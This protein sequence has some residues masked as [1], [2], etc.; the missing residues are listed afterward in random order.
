MKDNK[1]TITGKV[2][3]YASV[4]SKVTG[5]VARMAGNKIIG[6]NDI[7][8]NADNILNAL[9]GLKGPLM[10]VAQ[11]LATIPDALPKEYAE[12]LQTLQSEAPSMGWFFVKRRMAGELGNEWLNKFEAFDKKAIKAASLGQVH[13]A[14]AN[15]IIIACK[16]QYPDMISIVDADLKQ[17]KLIFTIYGTW[18][19]T[20][21]TKDIYEELT[22][23]LKEE[24]DYNKEQKNMLLFNEILKNEKY[25]KV[26]K[27]IKKLSTDKLLTMTWL[28]GD[29]IM[30]WKKAKSEIK[31]HLAL[32]LFNAWYI[33]F[34]KY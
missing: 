28:E 5:V 18:D 26:P 13:K 10:K 30:N 19:K 15:G 21:K 14:K 24:L 2:K 6:N 31:N 12:K 27:P 7:N 20:I 32:T 3:R 25:I 9:G 8:K 23:R 1:A 11:L 33:P 17:L 4:S 16:L 22:N 29:S 34:Y